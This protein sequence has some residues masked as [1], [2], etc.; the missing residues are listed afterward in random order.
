MKIL[1]LIEWNIIVKRK[2][3]RREF[4]GELKR[5]WVWSKSGTERRV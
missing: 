1:D 3:E 5:D 2:G 4:G